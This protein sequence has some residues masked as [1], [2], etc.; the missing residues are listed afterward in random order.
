MLPW[1]PDAVAVIAALAQSRSVDALLLLISATLVMVIVPGIALFYGGMSGR[2]GAASAF[3]T[4]LSGAAVVI[5]LAVLGGYGLLAGTP[6]IAHLLGRPD[7]GLAS[8]FAQ[9]EAPSSD[10]YPLAHAGYLIALCAVAVAVLGAAVA[11]RVTVRAW[12]VFV[13]LWSPLV[14]FPAGYA[15]F[16]LSDGWAVAGMRAIDFGGALPVSLAAG[17]GA[18]GVILACGRHGH[19]PTGTHSLPLVAAGGA[20]VWVGWFGLTVGSEGALDAFTPLIWINTLIA[21]AG[22]ALCWVIVDR[23]MLRRPTITSVLCGAVSGL[24]AITPA[25][26]VVTTGWSLLL[27]ALAAL[28]CATMVDVAA[29]VRFGVPM[30]IC[31]IHIVASLVGM[32]FI[33]LFATGEGMIDSGNFDLFVAQAIAAFGIAAWSFLVSLAIAWLLRVTLGL[34]PVRYRANHDVPD[35]SP[36]RAGERAAAEPE[37]EEGRSSD[38]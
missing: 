26:G 22:G 34:T 2:A 25:S 23:V 36:A 8:L 30:T 9:A 15:V 4:V 14:L 13:V 24:V 3:R 32:L 18:A 27:G 10:P 17:S 33:G 16:A 35:E 6:W 19:A 31:V 11:S 29:R 7:P 5:V 21:S 28:A 37:G 38:S 20:L 1:R 12:L